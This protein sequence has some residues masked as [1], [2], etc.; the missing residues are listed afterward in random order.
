M[1]ITDLTR[2]RITVQPLVLDAAHAEAAWI[3]YERAM[4]PLAIRA[5][6]RH[7]L[8]RAE[9]GDILGDSRIQKHLAWA[10]TE[11]I[12]IGTATDQ[13]EAWPLISPEYY[14]HRWPGRV[15]WY[16]GF[17]AVAPKALGVL[18]P[19]IDRLSR[20]ARRTGG[21]A[22]ADFCA[23]NIDHRKIDT[24][25]DTLLRH[26]DPHT[27]VAAVDAQEFHAWSFGGKS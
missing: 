7:L 26:L 4:R 23:Y 11:L 8:T 14:H 25:I 21:I 20:E 27:T 13:L 1:T 5:A 24:R 18:G 9:F 22:A 19:L 17:V 3:L 10:G 15:V 6:Q 12:G 16:I 2:N